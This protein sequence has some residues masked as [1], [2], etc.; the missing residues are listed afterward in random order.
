MLPVIIQKF[1]QG[2]H[3]SYMGL[4][5]R[6]GIHG[7]GS[8][9]K[10]PKCPLNY[11]GGPDLLPM[12]VRK[13]INSQYRIEILLRAIYY[14]GNFS[15]P[16][17]PPL[18]KPL[19]CLL[20]TG[21]IENLLSFGRN[22]SFKA[23]W[24]IGPEVSYLERVERIVGYFR[25]IEQ[26]RA[27]ER[28]DSFLLKYEDLCE[29]PAYFLK[30]LSYWI[31]GKADEPSLRKAVSIVQKQS[32]KEPVGNIDEDISELKNISRKHGYSWRESSFLSL[33]HMRVEK[34]LYDFRT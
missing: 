21:C 5:S 8:S 32:N 7:P 2:K 6:E 24:R 9:S 25:R 13:F 34:C 33:A 30:E 3:D 16:S 18:L 1:S 27:N 11:I 19:P 12:S 17:D 31:F 22:N 15:F 14:L 4:L 10:L 29:K 28:L 26:F 23:F 20:L